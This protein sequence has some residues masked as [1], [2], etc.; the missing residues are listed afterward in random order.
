M[1]LRGRREERREERREFGAGGS[2]TRFR[3]RQKLVSFGDD[4]WIEDDAGNH[5]FR[6]D[7]KA[8]RLRN[9]LDLEDA[10]GTHLYRIQTRVMHLRDSMAI[11]DPH[12]ERVALVHK[13]LISPL[14]ERWKVDL[15]SGGDLEVQ[16]N[17]VDHEYGIE[18]D[19]RKVAEISKKW[20]RI[21]D[22]YGVQVAPG[23]DV[24]LILAVAVAVDAMAHP[25]N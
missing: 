6:V 14:R 22:T 11:E 19:G 10:H 5:V 3:M 21:R 9:T 23:A 15:D 8:L 13:A 4:F 20:F 12:G 2:A 18:V 17:V 25:S 16:G 1:G 7:G 24:P